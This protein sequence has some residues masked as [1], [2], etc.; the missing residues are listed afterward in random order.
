MFNLFKK[1]NPAD[2]LMKTY[3]R[4]QEEAFQLSRTDRKAAD[5]KLAEAEAILREIEALQ[6]GKS[7]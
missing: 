5:A 1:T 4:L 7:S 3:K 6:Q 2:R